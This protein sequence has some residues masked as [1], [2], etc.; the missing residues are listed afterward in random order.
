[1]IRSYLKVIKPAI[2]QV[3]VDE[4]YRYMMIKGEVSPEVR[5]L[6]EEIMPK[7]LA[8]L[9]CKLVYARVPVIIQGREVQLGELKAVSKDLAKNLCQIDEAIVFLATIGNGYELLKKG[10][11]V[12]GADYG[13]CADAIGTAAVEALCDKFCNE[14]IPEITGFYSNPRFSPG[15]GDLALDFQVS[16]LDFLQSKEAVGVN[17]N[18]TLLMTPQKSV[19]AITGLTA[20][21]KTHINNCS[22]CQNIDCEFKRDRI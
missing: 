8:S 17:L 20:N 19:S 7:V 3:P 4:V 15:Y 11:L 21:N 14:I 10:L 12:K 9:D 16:F 6:V 2:T 18:D 13:L 1:M 5:N 22:S